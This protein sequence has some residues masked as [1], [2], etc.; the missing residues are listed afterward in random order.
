[1][2]YRPE[3]LSIVVL[4][5]NR[6]ELTHQL[7]SDIKQHCPKVGEVIVVNNGSED[8]NVERGLEFW[9]GLKVLPLKLHHLDENQGFIGGM[10]FGI[11]RAQEELVAVISNDVRI[12]S[13][14]FSHLVVDNF[15][16]DGHILLGATTYTQDTGWNRFGGVVHPYLSGHFLVATKEFWDITNGFDPRYAPSDYEDVDLS[17]QA[18]QMGYDLIELPAGTI[19]HIGGGTYGYNPERFART[20]RNRIKYAEKWGVPVEP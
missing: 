2:M 5:Y 10:N 17:Q 8:P 13:S 15:N 18:L 9:K 7:L 4:C 12:T 14:R 11:K 19:Q 6:Y 16:R 3:D 20:Q 1:M